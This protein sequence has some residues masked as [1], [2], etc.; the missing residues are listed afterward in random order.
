MAL[1][2]ILAAK[3]GKSLIPGGGGK[4]RADFKVNLDLDGFVKAMRAETIAS[5]IVIAQEAVI[6]IRKPPPMKV[7]GSGS[8]VPIAEE[9]G[10]TLRRS[11]GWG[12]YGKSGALSALQSGPELADS[13]PQHTGKPGDVAIAT[14]SGY[15]GWVHE[16][17]RFMEERPFIRQGVERI[18]AAGVPAKA[19]KDYEKRME[20]RVG[21]V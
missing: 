21:K 9:D 3:I 7:D 20:D 8:G 18:V 19:Y 17:T 4:D 5:N 6:E 15:G 11:T 14:S 13:S 2:I 16:G 10:G 1:P 12:V